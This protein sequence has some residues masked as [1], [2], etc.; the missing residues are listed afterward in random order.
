M[1]DSSSL[2]DVVELDAGR[3]II[4][5]H[6][7]IDAVYRVETGTVRIEQAGLMHA[8]IAGPGDFFGESALAPGSMPHVRAVA[9]TA[10]K[11]AKFHRS[12]LDKALASDASLGAA[13]ARSLAL[14]LAALRHAVG[15]APRPSFDSSNTLPPM[16]R[17]SLDIPPASP[18]SPAESTGSR[19]Q[20]RHSS[21][22]IPLPLERG[23]LLIGR[24][25]PATGTVPDIDLSPLDLARGLSRRHA[26]V[27]HGA[28]GVTLREEPR[29]ANGTWVN[30]RRLNPG[31]SVILQL[32]DRLRFG[33][34]ELVFD[35]G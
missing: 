19:Y 20:F 8:V 16:M 25:D 18:R 2:A 21:L 7:P 15:N 17:V 33:A 35:R 10:V 30:N 6:Q 27:W 12:Q 32:G 14:H 34:V 1:S 11:L 4:D 31:E 23:H 13:M 5:F 9:V 3:V 22:D 29:V 24:P 28:N 26:R